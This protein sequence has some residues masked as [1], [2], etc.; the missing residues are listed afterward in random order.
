MREKTAFS[1]YWAKL[2]PMLECAYHDTAT[3]PFVDSVACNYPDC[4]VMKTF[5]KNCLKTYGLN[6]LKKQN[7]FLAT[8]LL[9]NMARYN[10]FIRRKDAIK[11]LE[12][13]R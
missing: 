10:E 11:K 12:H 3:C 8:K 6:T 4:D 2:D 9:L 1:H 13:G 5:S 7:V